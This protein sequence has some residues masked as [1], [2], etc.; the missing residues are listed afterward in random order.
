VK[1]GTLKYPR[2]E[3]RKINISELDEKNS[4]FGGQEI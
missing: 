3:G 4:P 2:N 1:L